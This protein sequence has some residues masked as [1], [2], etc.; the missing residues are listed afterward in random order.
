MKWNNL[1]QINSEKSFKKLQKVI[2]TT[3]SNLLS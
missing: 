2:L 3:N 1:F